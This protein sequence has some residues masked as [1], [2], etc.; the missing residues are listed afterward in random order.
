M[1]FTVQTCV[2]SHLGDRKD[3]Q[4]R[5]DIF[6]D[7]G[8]PGSFVAVLADGMGGHGG[9]GTAAEQVL[10]QTRQNFVVYDPGHDTP[11]RFL[12]S[13]MQEAHVLIKLTRFTTELK[14][15]STAVV[16]MMQQGRFY[17]GH[18]GDSRLYHFRGPRLLARTVD[19]SL[20]G[21]MQ[22][23]GQ[24]TEQETL[25]HAQ[26]NVV[27]NCLGSDLA[28]RVELGSQEDPQ[29]GDS[30][31]LCSDGLWA[32]FNDLELG[33]TLDVLP[34]RLAAERLI[35]DARRRAAGEGDNL[36][37]AIIKLLPVAED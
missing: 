36:S 3:Q 29:P 6:G 13:A 24:L 14:P 26:R 28:P 12:T 10:L 32:Y 8:K 34:P 35:A 5:V 15:H 11:Q 19:H 23:R 16:L 37:L 30:F 21:E 18:C 2:A 20:V 22:R 25:A 9:G 33:I 31:L 4:D 7:P 1:P 17:W 27:M